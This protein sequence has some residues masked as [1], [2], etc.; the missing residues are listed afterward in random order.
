MIDHAPPL[1]NSGSGDD[2]AL[3]NPRV[4]IVSMSFNSFT[5]VPLPIVRSVANSFRREAHFIL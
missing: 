2:H 4:K 1:G 5:Y 3:N